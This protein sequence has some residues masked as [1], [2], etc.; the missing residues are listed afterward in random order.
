MGTLA[1]SWVRFLYLIGA[2]AYWPVVLFPYRTSGTHLAVDA[3][4][5]V[6]YVSL[7]P[8]LVGWWTYRR[9]ALRWGMAP[10][11]QSTWV[12]IATALIVRLAFE[13]LWRLPAWWAERHPQTTRESGHGFPFLWV[14]VLFEAAYLICYVGL[15][16]VLIMDA[17]RAALGGP[18]AS[19]T[20]R[21]S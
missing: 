9:W 12:G 21:R 13:S 11:P 4:V 5:R 17:V 14:G 15:V 16:F 10:E 3:L 8:F 18:L 6:L 7:P 20:S 19:A 1:T 2:M